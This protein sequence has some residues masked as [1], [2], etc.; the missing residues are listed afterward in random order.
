M[1]INL[2]FQTQCFTKKQTRWLRIARKD[3]HNDCCNGKTNLVVPMGFVEIDSEEMTYV[4]GGAMSIATATTVFNIAIAAG[5]LVFNVIGVF[6]AKQLA[7]KIG[8]GL[9]R[10]ILTSGARNALQ[11][12]IRGASSIFGMTA[13]IVTL[14][15]GFVNTLA[16]E[17]FDWSAGRL[18]AELIA[19]I[20]NNPIVRR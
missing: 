7:G 18:V 1:E 14:S 15:L 13:N 5:M 11:A 17:L 12:M 4:E 8:G 10:N 16:S 2:Y 20:P 3:V 19:R 6:K 9:V